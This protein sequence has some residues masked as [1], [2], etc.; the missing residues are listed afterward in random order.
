MK[1]LTLF[2]V[3]LPAL[4]LQIT[5]E[6]QPVKGFQFVESSSG[7]NYPTW[8]SGMTELEFAD[9]NL[10]GFVDILSIGDHGCPNT[11]A[12]EHGIMVWFGDGKGNWSVQMTG[13]FGYGG[14]AIGD[15]NKDGIWDVGYGMHHNYATSDLGNQKIEVALGDG[16]GTN[17]NAWDDGLASSGEA[18]GMFGTDFADIDNDGDLDI[19]SNSMGAGDGVHVYLNNGDGTWQQ[20]FGFFAGN[21]EMR[22]LFGDLN[23]DGN[24]D[25]VVSN[26]AGTAWF[27]DGAGS[28]SLADFNLPSYGWPVLG[29][30]LGDVNKDGGMELAYA[31]PS[32]GVYVWSFDPTSLQWVN[33]S[34]TLPSSG[35]YQECQLCD[36]DRDGTL[37]IAAFGNAQLTLWKGFVESPSTVSW[38]QQM[39]MTTSNNGDC[40]ALRAGG[41]VD[42]NG[43]PDLALVEKVG[44]WPND[45]NHLKCFKENSPFVKANI[46][47]VFPLGMEKF[48]Q[49]S[50]QFVDWISAVPDSSI[51]CVKIEY[52]L[53]GTEGPWVTITS[54]AANS[55]HYQWLLPMTISTNNCYIRLTLTEEEDTL[56]SLTPQAFTILGSNGLSADFKA[57]PTVTLPDSPVSFT[58][59]SLGLVTSWAWD[60]N[61]DGIVDATDRNPEYAYSQPGTYTVKLTVTDGI[62]SASE[63]KTDYITVLPHVGLPQG[64]EMKRAFRIYPN[65][66]HDYLFIS[67][68]DLSIVPESINFFNAAGLK[69]REILLQDPGNGFCE[70]SVSNLPVGLYYYEVQTTSGCQRGTILR[71]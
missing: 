53:Q 25:M 64:L 13:D 35:N 12:Q 59:Q 22:F 8:E 42:R 52:S 47:A 11:G 62:L 65:P 68:E 57:D 58:D 48:R 9:I 19:G 63:P 24:V 71:K 54:T 18:W 28:F 44:N 5:L 37:D 51:S 50:V 10:D 17:W 26:E 15:V 36:F 38:S 27:G 56:V 31:S 14:I 61:N 21:S 43:Y 67:W 6:A 16:T 66:C 33:L 60:F 55:G 29:P 30:D 40:N 34:G 41:D 45:R 39:T 2:A 3:L 70:V 1:K 32:G 7:M 20:S 23:N 69:V 46:S 4:L 49:G